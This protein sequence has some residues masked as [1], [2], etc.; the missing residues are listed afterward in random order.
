MEKIKVL[1]LIT[2]MDRAGAE[3]VM[4]NYM[5]KL[6]RD[7]FCV[8]FL[9]NR[10]DKADYEEEIEA[11]GGTVYRMSPLYPW[12]MKSYVRELRRLVKEKKRT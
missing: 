5:R 9:I 4:M 11:L 8:D 2:L 10:P 3:T 1:V 12:T 6:N 7:K